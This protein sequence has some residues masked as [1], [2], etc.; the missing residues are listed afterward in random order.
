[1]NINTNLTADIISIL[2]NYWPSYLGVF[3]MEFFSLLISKYVIDMLSINYME[4]IEYIIT[5]IIFMLLSIFLYWSIQTNRWFQRSRYTILFHFFVSFVIITTIFHYIYPCYIEGTKNDII[6]VR[7]WLTAIGVFFVF[8]VEYLYIHKER[9]G[10]CIV[11][12][13][14]NHSANEAT[15]L[16]S[17]ARA[18][19]K[20]EET[21]RNIQI[22]I[23]PFGIA[24]NYKECKRYI[25]S[26]F[27]QADA[28]I[29]SSIIDSPPGSEFGYSFSGFSSIMNDRNIK[30][31]KHDNESVKWFMEESTRC[32]EW[33]TLNFTTNQISRQ[34]KIAAN[35]TNLFLM[36]V[37]CIYLQKHKYSDAIGVADKLYTYNKTGITRFDDAVRELLAHSYISA[38]YIEEYDNQN[39]KRATEILNECVQ[40]LP[41]IRY[42]LMYCLSMARLYFY[43]GD[44]KMS[45]KMTKDVK[46]Q[47][48]NSDWYVSINRA[49]FAIYEKKAKEMVTNYRR[50]LKLQKQDK[51]EVD[52]AIRFLMIESK[53]SHDKVYQMY[54]THGI[55]YLYLYLDQRESDKYLNDTIIFAGVNGYQELET[56]RNLIKNSKGKLGV[57]K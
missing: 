7:Y 11:F 4:N 1:M 37:S 6:F 26:I 34:I 16:Q 28:V 46:D 55:A 5:W 21:T 8:L 35:L 38:L 45:K 54:L 12:W 22:V 24:Q 44:I 42:T 57:R 14:N 13:V 40:K 39:Y 17:L 50:L 49:F 25:N 27:N 29:F 33:N 56:M 47:F 20:V 23:P 53:R 19:T 36:Y 30:R 10:I 15:I 52:F 9:K 32:Y 2:K 43:K 51:E 31:G 3:V 48:P 18:R 41:Q